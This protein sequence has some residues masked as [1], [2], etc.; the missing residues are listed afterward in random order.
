MEE[1]I[2]TVSKAWSQANASLFKHVS[3]YERKLNEFL[4]KM[5]GWIRE[6]EERIW[7]MIFQIAGETG[8]PLCATLDVLFRLLETLPSFPPNLSYQ[9]QSPVI[10]RFAPE[11]YAQPWLGLHS[12]N[13]P[14]PPSFDSCRKTEDVLKE[15]IIHSTRG[16]T[17]AKARALPPASTSTAPGPGLEECQRH[18]HCV[19]F[20]PVLHPALRS[21][22]KRQMH[23]IPLSTTIA[24]R[25][26]LRG[27]FGIR[28]Q[29]KG[30]SIKF[31]EFIRIEFQVQQW[32]QV[33]EWVPS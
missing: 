32:Q 21:P 15:A 30:K 18:F 17:V 23:Q 33:P 20:P 22:S 13:L 28:A 1:I 24:I 16:S 5:G 10:C 12:L 2:S 3:D 6:Q 31:I 11:D 27:E 26:L 29:I 25:L 7:T 4:D 8:A 14:H 9:S 19:F